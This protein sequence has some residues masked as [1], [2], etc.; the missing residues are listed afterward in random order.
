M[1]VCVYVC[2]CLCNHEDNVTMCPPNYYHNG[3]VGAYALGNM[4]SVC[5]VHVFKCISCHK[6]IVATNGKVYCF[7]NCIYITPIFFL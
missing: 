1:Y 3:F 7:H 5:S 6:A 2:I 4:M